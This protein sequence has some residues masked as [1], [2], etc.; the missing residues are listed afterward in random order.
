MVKDALVSVIIPVHNGE[1]FIERTLASALAQTYEPLE[2]IVVDDGSTDCAPKLIEAAAARDSRIRLFR[3]EK[4]GVAATRNFGNSKARGD[5]IAS[6]DADDLWH[7]KKIARQVDVMK[8]SSAKVGLVY[9]W[10]IEIDENDFVISSVR[11]L[12]LQCTYQ[13]RVTADLATRCFIETASSP[14]IKRSCIEA[15]GGYDMALTP[16]GA[17]DWKLYLA[18]SEICEFAVVPEYLVG[19]RQWS[20]SLSRDMARIAGSIESVDRWITKKWPDLP[21]ELG[22][23]RTYEIYGYLALRAIERNQFRKA[24]YFRAKAYRA[25]PAKLLG[26]SDFKFFGHLLFRMIGLR[27]AIFRQRG[28]AFRPFV[29]FAELEA[30]NGFEE[31]PYAKSRTVSSISRQHS[32]LESLGKSGN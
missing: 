6:L 29:P 24:L 4:S 27:A 20:G 31:S 28:W 22:R 8:A 7:P 14:L 18:L 32:P 16:Q 15:V 5:L 11:H 13:G 12:G 17:D 10:S 25:G 1:R 26:R 9:C 30:A 3:T 2:F 19:Y 23:K 21:E